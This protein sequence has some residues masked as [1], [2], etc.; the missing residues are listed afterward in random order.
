MAN[1]LDNFT[2]S[3]GDLV[4]GRSDARQEYFKK[5][6]EGT[7]IV[8]GFAWYQ[9]DDFNNYFS[10]SDLDA[11]RGSDASYLASKRQSALEKLEQEKI[12]NE[13]GLEKAKGLR[14]RFIGKNIPESLWKTQIV[15]PETMDTRFLYAKQYSDSIQKSRFNPDSVPTIDPS[16]QVEAI[17]LTS[18]AEAKAY[19]GLYRA[20]RRGCKF[21]IGMIASEKLFASAKVHFVLDMIDMSTVCGK[22]KEPVLR[23]EV[24]NKIKTEPVTCAELRY[25]FRNW[26]KLTGKVLFY[27][28][29][30]EVAA[31]WE[32]DWT[33]IDILGKSINAKKAEWEGYHQYREKKY[34]AGG[35]IPDKSLT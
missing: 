35:G 21:G 23:V 10:V 4:Y 31:P 11:Y 9:L 29:L 14:Q 24:D 12:S 6:P 13:Q 25:V 26:K 5:V 32:E 18:S 8:M 7:R 15:E 20:L 28:N 19:A 34:E 27:V 1:F 3:N 16:N 2:P 33:K 30:E 22:R 17:N